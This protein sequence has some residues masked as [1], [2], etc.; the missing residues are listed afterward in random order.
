MNHGRVLTRTILLLIGVVL[1]LSA[2]VAEPVLRMGMGGSAGMAA[3]PGMVV[4]AGMAA[5]AAA[6]AKTGKRR[7]ASGIPPQPL[8]MTSWWSGC[9][10][11]CGIRVYRDGWRRGV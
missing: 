8:Q 5:E 4:V 6:T 11:A 7:R 9:A 1:T 10:G 3:S 2:C